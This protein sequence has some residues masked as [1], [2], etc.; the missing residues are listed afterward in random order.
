VADLQAQ[1]AALTAQLASL[2]G[3]SSVGTSGVTYTFAK[4]LQVG[5]TGE[6]VRMLQKVLNSSADTKVASTGAGSPG[7]ETT[8]FGPATK[9]AVIKFQNKYAS[10][11][12]TPVGLTKGTGF[13]GSATRAKLNAMSTGGG[14]TG[15]G[16]TTPVTGTVSVTLDATSPA[17]GAVIQGQAL[18]DLAH[19]RLTNTSGTE[20]RITKVVLSRTGISSDSTLSNV[21][22]FSGAQ[23]VTD[24]ATVSVGKITFINASGI[25]TIPA[26][27]SVVLSVQADIA[28]STAGQIVGVALDSAES[29]VTVSGALPI[30]SSFQS[31]AAA[32][33]G[34]VALTYTGPSSATDNPATEV[35]VFEAQTVVSTHK[36]RLESVTFENR[37]TTKDGDLTNL[38]LYVDGVQVGSTVA[39][40]TNDRA[41]FDLKSSP[42]SLDT[43]TRIIKVLADVVGG[44][45]YTYSVQIRRASDLRVVDAELNQ[46]ILATTFPVAAGTAN[47]ISGGSLSVSRAASS[48]SSNV[49]VGGTNVKLATFEFRASGEDVK[50]EAITVDADTSASAGGLDNGKVFVNGS[51]VGSTLDIAEG[52]TTEFTFGSSFVAKAGAVTTVDIYADAKTSTSTNL[53][54]NETV[55]V[56]VSIASAD[57]EGLNSGNTV[58]AISEVE[59]FSRTVSASSLS[60]AKASGYGN[61]TMIAGTNN[62]K[63]GSFTLSAGSTEGINV[64]TIVVNLSSAN[65]AS[66]TDLMLKDASGGAQI[67]T[68]KA[69]P[70]TDNSFSANVSIP[71]SGTKTIDIYGSIKS[72]AE[73]GSWVATIDSTT[74]GTG[75]T[76]ANSA[77][78][79][80]DVTLQTITVGSGTITVAVN[81]GS[82]P[83]SYNAVAGS[84]E[85]KVGTFR[86]TAQYS[87]FT[88]QELKVKVPTDAATSVSAVI[89]KWS[90][91]SASGALTLPSVAG[92]THATSTF[93]G[94]S[95]QIPENTSKDL[96]VY[97][98]IPTIASGASTGKAISVLIDANEGFKAVDG[99]GTSDTTAAAADLN[100][101]ATSGKGTE[102]VRKSIP[103]LSAV[104]LDSTTLSAGSN[105]VLGR[106]KVTADAA[107]DVGWKKISFT[108][109]KTAAITLGATTTLALW[110]GSNQIGG[111]FGTTTGNL[112]GTLDSLVNLTSGNLTF[113][114]TSEKEIAAGTSKT[115]ELRGT[116]GGLASGS[117]SVSVSIAN[118]SASVTTGTATGVAA[119]TV[120]SSPSFGWTDRSSISTVH[121]ESTSDWTTDYLVKT[122]PLTV[123]DRSVNF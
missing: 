16:T 14:T 120:A 87:P 84:S 50:I 95:F 51:Q 99:A 23:R 112:R 58:T 88:V 38:K 93:T 97:V 8:Y 73:A 36:A 37:G 60:A 6:D 78:V 47:N 30:A 32:S 70:S 85:V 86:F 81:D 63:L 76:T 35:R 92:E 80:S 106:V 2:T 28:G 31:V 53:I 12:L 113:V 102:Y 69:S 94:L 45:S 117:N 29:N 101:A 46:P 74:G 121:S 13:V 1:L 115:Y 26:G 75:A 123:G 9:A 83:N 39:K 65:A 118:A 91:G 11:V 79:G 107:G 119:D 25:V 5:S 114:A 56:G 54:N 82:T 27:G 57:T 15:G 103:T 111:T 7:S 96:D 109:N 43:G 24:A 18:A 4:N 77:T 17:Q 100:S 22:L 61:Q 68:T 3:G 67:G 105:Q 33:L 110:D 34:T 72:G 62:V 44:S 19:Y 64:N 41:T 42:V 89:L 104:A 55:D 59:G 98:S 116:V 108:V 90:G 71:A 66:V 20:A 49:S 10:D 40:F 48:P 52:A 21:Y 122:L